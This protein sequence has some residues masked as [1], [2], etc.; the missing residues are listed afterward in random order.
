MI[1][2]KIQRQECASEIMRWPYLTY[3]FTSTSRL[4]PTPLVDWTTN[5]HATISPTAI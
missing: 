1:P 5:T 2:P 4:A 3:P